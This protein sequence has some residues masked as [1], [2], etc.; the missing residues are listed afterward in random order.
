[1]T[2]ETPT[3][4]E[5]T[6]SAI[7]QAAL[8]LFIAQGYHGTSMR[9]IAKE[10]GIALGGIY[11]HFPSKEAI[12]EAVFLSHHPYNDVLPA[13]E[14]AQGESVEEL[15]RDA[16]SQMAAAIDKR[17]N[18]INLM[19][20]EIV[21]FKS[22]HSHALFNTNLPRSLKIVEGHVQP[23]SNL[24]PIPLPMMIRLF[25]GQFISYYI[26]E[27]IIGGSL[28]L[29]FQEKAKEYFIDHF[30]HGILEKD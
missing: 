19:F 21:E 18:F 30:L 8:E 2:P 23:D 24:R 9:Q 7:T 1:M 5:I 29:G 25:F 3:R 4:G 15:V 27:F 16:F 28:P 14:S 6:S 22:A 10:A 26:T 11:N 13:L 20:I 17:P 12:F